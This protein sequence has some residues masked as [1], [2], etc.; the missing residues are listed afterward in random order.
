[1]EDI[2]ADYA[3]GSTGTVRAVIGEDLRPGNVW[4]VSELPALKKNPNVE[5]IITIDPVTKVETVLFTRGI[6]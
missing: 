3:K 6:Q 4:E 5:K 2:S 1:M